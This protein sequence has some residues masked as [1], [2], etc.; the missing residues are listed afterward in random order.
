MR[1]LGS[2][3]ALQLA[4]V[5][6]FDANLVAAE[7]WPQWRGPKRD[8]VSTET[9]LMKSWPEDGPPRVWLFEDCGVGY[10]APAIV[11]DRLY[12]MGARN[13]GEQVIAIDV[14]T[15][16]E[17]WQAPIGEMLKNNWGDGPRGTPTVD[18]EFVYALGAQGNLI[19]VR[20]DNGLVV[21]TRAMQDFGGK[22][23]TW[24]YAE[25][26]LIYADKLL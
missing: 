24:G 10:S 2:C 18:G 14:K 7:D 4:L 9:G 6:A 20:A 21:W 22:I 16:K 5:V 1:C 19:C 11:G 15:G 13:D 8:A 17:V 25:S 23:P 3:A 12:T 26:P